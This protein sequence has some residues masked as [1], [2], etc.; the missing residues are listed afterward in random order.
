MRT[1]EG[2]REWR[3]LSG[4]PYDGASSSMSIS[5]C[6]ALF[7]KK[8]I[9]YW[10]TFKVFVI[11]SKI[12]VTISHHLQFTGWKT[13]VPKR[14]IFPLSLKEQVFKYN[15]QKKSK[16]FQITRDTIIK[17]LSCDKLVYSK[18]DRMLKTKL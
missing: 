7:L 1:S 6:T 8:K 13:C 14:N 17:K 9:I 5:K 16:L 12:I 11:I 18:Y 2:H 15:F 3:F 4:H 10:K